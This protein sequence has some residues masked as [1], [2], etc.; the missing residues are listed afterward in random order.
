VGGAAITW[1]RRRGEMGGGVQQ[2]GIGEGAA[3][4][5]GE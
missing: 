4:T 5:K 2:R 1:G 3:A